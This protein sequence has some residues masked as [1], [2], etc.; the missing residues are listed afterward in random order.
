MVKRNPGPQSAKSDT[1]ATRALYNRRAIAAVRQGSI[2]CRKWH[3]LALLS[4]SAMQ[5]QQVGDRLIRCSRLR[6][7]NC[8]LVRESDGMTL[9]DTCTAGSGV[10]LIAVARAAGS[11][12][13]RIV[14]THAHWDHIGGLAELHAL[15]PDVPIAI[16]MREARLLAGDGSLDPNEPDRPIPGIGRS[17]SVTPTILLRDG[18]TIGSLKAVATPGHTPG[19]MSFFD[20][21]NNTLIAGDAL[22]TL[23]LGGL[24]VAGT[25]RW[26]MPVSAWFTWDRPSALVSARRLAA[27][28]PARIAPGHGRVIERPAGAFDRAIGIAQRQFQRQTLR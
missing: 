16:G 1:I 6:M 22:Y 19:H 28:R 10:R 20:L 9:V 17:S 8:Y 7:F 5:I 2:G 4:G 13:T 25:F 26:T 23:G 15:L 14:L 21:R 18:E 11:E 24:G 3:V 27:L 12:I